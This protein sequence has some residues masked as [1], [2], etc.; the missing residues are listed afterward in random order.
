M[1]ARQ[2]IVSTYLAAKWLDEITSG[3][4]PTY[5]SLFTSNPHL[6]G[7]PLTV[8]LIGPSYVRAGAT[9]AW[10]RAGR[11]LTCTS[12]LLWSSIPPGSVITHIGAFDAAVNGNFLFAGPVPN[13]LGYYSFSNGGYLQIAP[14]GWHVGLDF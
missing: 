8:E 1:T 10:S 5:M 3:A 7:N 6:A 12:V 14:N 11:L 2:G 4:I 9:G 13:A